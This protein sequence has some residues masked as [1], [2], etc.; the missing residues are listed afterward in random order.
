MAHADGY[1]KT[2]VTPYV[3]EHEPHGRSL[4]RLYRR[5]PVI[6]RTEPRGTYTGNLN[7]GWSGRHP[8]LHGA[9]SESAQSLFGSGKTALR[10]FS[11]C[12]DAGPLVD[13]TPGLVRIR[14]A[15]F[16]KDNRGYV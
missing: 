8:L 13:M 2:G 4:R 16:R 5:P 11:T 6:Q 10:R 9:G 1:A 3:N 7:R 14:L 15:C 12:F